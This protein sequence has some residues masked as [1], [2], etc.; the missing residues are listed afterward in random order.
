MCVRVCVSTR[1]LSQ[2]KTTTYINGPY[3]PPPL[4]GIA[5]VEHIRAGL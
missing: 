2:N 5:L 1:Y 3:A 4:P